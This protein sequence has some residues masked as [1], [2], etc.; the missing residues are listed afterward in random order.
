MRKSDYKRLNSLYT[1]AW[2]SVCWLAA[3][4]GG[5]VR[6]IQEIRVLTMLHLAMLVHWLAQ[7]DVPLFADGGAHNLHRGGL[8]HTIV[9]PKIRFFR[10]FGDQG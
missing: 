5:E 9:L 8:I 10:T 4:E 3:V 2:E 7:N 1:D 6:P